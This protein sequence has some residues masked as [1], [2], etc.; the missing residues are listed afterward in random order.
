MNRWLGFAL[1]VV[2]AGALALRLPQ[3]DARP[4]HND[5]AVNAIKLQSLWEKGE[6]R[7]DPDEYHG[8]VLLYAALPALWLS[9]AKSFAQVKEG[10]L[11]VVPV[12]F[13]AAMVLLLWLLK[14]GLGRAATLFAGVL[15]ALSPAMVFYSRY[16][17][18]EMLL[19]SFTA[20]LLAA[21]WRYTQTKRAGW[22]ALAGGAAG[23]M[24]ATKETFVITL[25]AMAGAAL[26]TPAW[27]AWRQRQADGTSVLRR[28]WNWR[29]A[30]LALLTAAGVAAVFF[31]SFFT[32]LSGLP[33]AVRTYLPWLNRASGASPQIYPWH[34]YLERLLWF[35]QGRGPVWTEAFILIL[36]AIGFVAALRGK[37]LPEARRS[38]VCFLAFYTGLLTA[39]YCAIPYKTPWCA[40]SFLHGWILLAGLGASV[41]L[42]WRTW[43][44]AQA[45][46]GAALAL[47]SGHLVWESIQTSFVNPADRRNP[48]VFAQTSPDLLELVEKVQA[49]ANVHPDGD[50]ML[51][52]VMMPGGDYWPLPWY[53]RQ[54]K[55]VGWWDKLPDDP[56]APVMIVG[57]KF[58]AAVE[59]KV[60][61]SHWMAGIFSLRP[62][63]AFSQR[64]PPFLE[65]YVESGLWKRYV[66]SRQNKELKRAVEGQK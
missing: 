23:L 44:S 13:C 19:V 21:G 43:R 33:D 52:K 50:Q 39:A 40:L 31:S 57:A 42:H 63:V 17:I 56:R 27:N 49:I 22:A 59:E 38:F 8:P 9:G 29:H 55:Q 16:F 30:L 62:P 7:Y 41:L 25:A 48:Y 61:E 37:G 35:H 64:A 65:L 26:L 18:H 28:L 58:Q 46:V 12:I 11:R 66:D 24:Y 45:L 53:L 2:T 34:F 54:F 4:M 3:M 5:E 60:E 20:L 47:L 32:N 51:I 6:Y 1:L 10:T 36:A 15:T 14:D